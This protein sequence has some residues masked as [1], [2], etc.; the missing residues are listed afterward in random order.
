MPLLGRITMSEVV[1][2]LWDYNDRCFE[3]CIY[4]G[5][6]DVYRKFKPHMECPQKI[7]ELKTKNYIDVA[8]TDPMPMPVDK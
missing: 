3:Y 6:L 7:L 5:I 8:F 1:I 4:L 2:D